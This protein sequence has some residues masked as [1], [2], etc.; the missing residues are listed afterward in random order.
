MFV[1]N[2]EFFQP[3]IELVP[4][5]AERFP[6]G[7][8]PQKIV[9]TSFRAATVTFVAVTALFAAPSMHSLTRLH[10]RAIRA[11]EGTPRLHALKHGELL[12]YE[13]A[14]SLE[15]PLNLRDLA[16]IVLPPTRAMTA[17]ERQGYRSM[18][19]SRFKPA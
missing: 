7:E 10:A 13:H 15:A 2:R 6:R 17:E 14:G 1:E 5:E 4:V 18:I 16:R 11:S 8:E 3:E 12:G 19:A 9:R